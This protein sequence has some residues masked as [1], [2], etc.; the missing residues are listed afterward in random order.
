[1]F[2]LITSADK[3]FAAISKVVRVRVEFSKNILNTDLPR[4][5]GTFLTSCEFR[6]KNDSAVSKICVNISRDKPSRL[7]RCCNCPSLLSCGLRALRKSAHGTGGGL[8]LGFAWVLAKDIIK[9]PS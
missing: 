7:S 5:S 8:G 2:R 6:A 3:R 4:N 9:T 1:M